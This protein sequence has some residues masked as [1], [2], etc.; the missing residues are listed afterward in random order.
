M[1]K[2]N[3]L[4]RKILSVLLCISLLTGIT[5]TSVSAADYSSLSSAVGSISASVGDLFDYAKSAGKDTVGETDFS[6]GFVLG[7]YKSAIGTAE[8]L[9]NMLL[10]SICA[11][12]PDPVTWKS[13]DKYSS[14]GLYNNKEYKTEAAVGSAYTFGYS[15]K[16]FI[17]DE[18]KASF[19]N[20]YPP[21]LGRLATAVAWKVMIDKNY[22]P[23][24][25]VLDDQ[26]VTAVCYDDGSGKPA[27]Q[28][29]IDSLGLAQGDVDAIKSALAEKY[30]KEF[31]SAINI[32]G[33]HTHC[34][35][36]V[37]GVSTPLIRTILV[38]PIIT[39][40]ETVL[41]FFG[42]NL[43]K[44]LPTENDV[45]RDAMIKVAVDAISEAYENMTPGK[46]YY[47]TAYAV[48]E[49]GKYYIAD[50][51]EIIKSDVLSKIAI[52]RFE[53]TDEAKRTTY[54]LNF[55]C[56][57]TTVSTYKHDGLVSSDYPYYLWKVFDDAGYNCIFTQGA[58]GMVANENV[59]PNDVLTPEELAAPRARD[60][61]EPLAFSKII[62]NCVM[63]AKEDGEE[64]LEPIINVKSKR[65]DFTASNF[66]LYLA[67]QTRLVNVT[68]YRKGDGIS[69]VVM[70]SE[71]SYVEFGR[72]AA[73]AFYP[74]ELYPEVF[75]GENNKD[76][77]TDTK[78]NKWNKA[79]PDTDSMSN[80][81]PDGVDLYAVCFANGYVGYVVPDNYY[82]AAGH[83]DENL[84]DNWGMADEPDE[85]M[86]AGKH[87]ASHLIDG[88]TQFMAEIKSEIK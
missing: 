5:A 72:K 62:F 74:C 84:P 10:M 14:E 53:P 31:F 16:S 52:L 21:V 27:A 57:P 73:F 11:V 41:R 82:A 3:T 29:T 87:T 60:I 50:K 69:D 25:G 2:K 15:R 8:K 51:R 17:T 40:F 56:H 88:F 54:L 42:I 13:V 9:L 71:M 77:Y 80:K 43:D 26:C 20:T 19:N 70:I 66:V 30:G 37:L 24:K 55:A 34:A 68:G 64:E 35:L 22:Y 59:K 23:A 79:I 47:D 1:K 33:T 38:N 75:F 65:I 44:R 78:W 46:L 6:Q 18:V 49:D 28:A 63:K 86:S 58:V 76:I 61:D 36:D 85:L 7:L 67:C 39:A 4:T 12:A 81:A 83:F 45:V 32:E 48:S